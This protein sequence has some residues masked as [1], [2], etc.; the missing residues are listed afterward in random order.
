[1]VSV[2]KLLLLGVLTLGDNVE[3]A[4][5]LPPTTGRFFYSNFKKTQFGG[6]YSVDMFAGED[7]ILNKKNSYEFNAFLTT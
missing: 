6:L 2:S 5:T 3:A 7:K 1:M 4:K